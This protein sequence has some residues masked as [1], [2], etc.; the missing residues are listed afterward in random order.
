[1]YERKRKSWAS[2]NLDLTFT[3]EY[4]YIASALNLFAHVSFTRART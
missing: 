4:S 2:L 3:R 1:M